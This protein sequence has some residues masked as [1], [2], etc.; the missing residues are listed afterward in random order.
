MDAFVEMVAGGRPNPCPPGEGRDALVVALAAERSRR[1]HRAVEV[2]E[3][4]TG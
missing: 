3:I 4:V 1:R 2:A